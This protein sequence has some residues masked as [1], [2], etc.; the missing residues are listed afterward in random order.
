M[1]SKTKRL[2]QDGARRSDREIGSDPGIIG[3]LTLS[4]VGTAYELKLH[5]PGD[6]SKRAPLLP[7]LFNANLVSMHGARM[8]FR[9]EERRGDQADARSQTYIQEWAVEVMVDQRARQ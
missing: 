2:R 8:L 4:G 9:G 5:A 1:Y 3:H 6:D 7:V